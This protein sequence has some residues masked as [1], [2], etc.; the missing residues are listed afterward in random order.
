ME[1]RESIRR[2]VVLI[3]L[4]GFGIN[5]SP[6][7]NAVYE[8]DTPRLDAWFAQ[9]PRTVLKASGRAAGLPEGQMGNS[10]VGHMTL[11]SGSVIRQ[12]LVLINDQ[13][14]SGA[15]FEN[16]V[17]RQACRRAR[18]KGRP[19]QLL[20][21]VSDGGVHSHIGHLLALIELCRQEQVVP[22]L[23]MMT[24]GRDTPPRSATDYLP[25][26]E[27]ALAQAGGSIVTLAGRYFAMDRDKRWDRTRL[28]WDM[29][30]NNVGQRAGSA[31]E[32]IEQAWASGIDDEFIKPVILPG[33]GPLDADDT[34]VFFNFRNDRP[35]QLTEA[36]VSEAFDGFDRG[37]YQA[38]E[39]SCL[40]EYDPGLGLPYCFD[41]E[42]PA[43]TLAGILADRGL[44]Q[45]HCAET[46][47]YAHVTFFF[48]GGRE[49]PFPGE[50]R[51]MVPSPDVATYDLAPE[52][53]AQGVADA[54]ID[55]INSDKYAFIVVNFANGDM[56]GHTAVHDAVIEAVETLDREVG[57]VLDTGVEHGY[58][59][60][61]TADHGNCDEMV[62]AATGEPHTQHTVYPVPCLVIDQAWWRLSINA[63]LSSVA[64]TVLELMGIAVPDAMSGESLLFSKVNR[65]L[66]A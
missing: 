57:R 42:R 28:A 29:I 1:H 64:P 52:M 30:V 40:T 25:A 13:V 63:G 61:L 56:V 46:E 62:D 12:D 27:A 47:K 49:D 41:S 38:P 51:V 17:L 3:I 2:P 55:A 53:S 33:A 59:V 26:V 24:D 45:F 54:V 6:Y 7:N 35:R 8:A 16:T 34:L 32:A 20:G 48:N 21:L 5:P 10:E 18:D 9:Y 31:A 19:L 22:H 36:L 15:F 14:E 66:K 43:V 37:D 58:S 23:H 50:D 65:P 11:G 39:L 4:D 60:V 44:K